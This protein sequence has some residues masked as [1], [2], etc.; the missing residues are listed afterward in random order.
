MPSLIGVLTEKIGNDDRV[1][2]YITCDGTYYVKY[3]SKD[4]KFIKNWAFENAPMEESISIFWYQKVIEYLKQPEGYREEV[5]S[6][7]ERVSADDIRRMCLSANRTIL[8]ML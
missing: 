5:I 7:L 3:V 8:N 1:E 2:W 4:G 6:I